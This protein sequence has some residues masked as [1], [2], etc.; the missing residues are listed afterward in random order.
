MYP[1]GLSIER[2]ITFIET[3]LKSA[4]SMKQDDVEWYTIKLFEL[5]NIID[6]EAIK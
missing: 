1:R 6:G 4:K 3:I 2:M 5:Q